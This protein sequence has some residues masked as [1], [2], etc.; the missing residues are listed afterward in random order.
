MRWLLV[1]AL[2]ACTLE[3]MPP[4]A[5]VRNGAPAPVKRVV[6]LPSECGTQLCKGLDA[7][8]AGELSFRGYEIVDLE[9]LAAIERK[10]TEIEVTWSK[11]VD[12]EQSSGGSRTV[13]VRGPTLSDV[14]IWSLREE[15]RAMGVDSIVRVRTAS[16]FGRPARV[17]ALVRVTRADDATLIASAL[18]ELETGTFD[19]YQEG[20]E[21]STRCALAKV[22]R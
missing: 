16:V 2:S 3:K 20:A 5:M 18:C 8:V 6:L 14:D 13:H 12:G 22:L 1:L 7:I 19:T 10:R 15:L 9:R 17:A 11:T 21:R 4:I